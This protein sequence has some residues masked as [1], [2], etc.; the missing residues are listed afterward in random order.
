MQSGQ[1]AAA[2][3]AATVTD[4]AELA[5]AAAQRSEQLRRILLPLAGGA[6]LLLV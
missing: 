2:P 5:F 6:A 3:A 4:A 1:L